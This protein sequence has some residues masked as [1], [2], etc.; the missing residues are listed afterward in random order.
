MK[1]KSII[2]LLSILIVPLSFMGCASSQPDD[3][4]DASTK[5]EK[6]QQELDDI[7]ALLGISG[8]D[9]QATDNPATQSTK[10][11]TDKSKS[12]DSEEKVSKDEKLNLLSTS[13]RVNISQDTGTEISS[14]EKKKLDNKIKTLQKKLD[15]KDKTIA[16]LRAQVT[17]QENELNKRPGGTSGTTV[18]SD[19]SMDEYQSRYDEARS[20]FED[21]NYRAAIQ[22]F[23][24][25]LA[26]SSTHPLAENAQYW[27]GECQYALRLYDASI[28]SFEKVFT[29][30]S[31]NKKDDA[32]FK[33]GLCYIR[34]KEFNKAK[35]E[36]N[37]LI[38]EYPKSEFLAKA[39]R[40]LEKM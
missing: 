26:A 17:M 14:A 22:L 31:P 15:A 1:L 12:A 16:D 36:L 23:E 4:A 18:I 24:S 3:Q 7:E 35:E 28:I 33:L 32:Q 38:E 37:R 39:N 25:L 21:H 34:K 40:L 29:F 13:D 11:E 5:D 20:E 10:N 19:I 30:A 2:Y 27:I 8:N 6:Q 9:E